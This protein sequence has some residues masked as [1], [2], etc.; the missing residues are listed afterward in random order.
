[1][2]RHIYGLVGLA[3]ISVILCGAGGGEK[4]PD[5]APSSPQAQAN[6]INNN[7]HMPPQAKAMA[8]GQLKAHNSEAKQGPR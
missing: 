2:T 6:Q 1:M 3:L 8:L 4:S 7:P 5:T